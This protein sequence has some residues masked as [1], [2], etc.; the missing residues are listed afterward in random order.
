MKTHA[1]LISIKLKHPSLKNQDKSLKLKI[2]D[3]E[4]EVVKKYL[5]KEIDNTLDW[6]EHM[7]AISSR[8]SRG[9]SFLM[10]GKSFLRKE[11]LKTMYFGATLPLFFG[12]GLLWSDRNQTL[13]KTTKPGCSYF[14][15][16]EFLYPWP[17]YHKMFGWRTIDKLITSESNI[18]VFKSV[19]ILAPQYICNLLTENP[20]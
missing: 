1:L 19:H 14:N 18:M 5:G 15:W 16:Q 9:I 2:Q 11:T 3:S 13:T 6:K 12:M 8:V 17:K 7:K 10:L 20:S 4:L